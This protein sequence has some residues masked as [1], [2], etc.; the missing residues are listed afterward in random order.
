MLH[1]S[2]SN[3]KLGPIPSV[4]LPPIETCNHLAPC[5]KGDCYACKGRFRFKSVQQS[6]WENLEFYN[7]NSPG[8]YFAEIEK[9]CTTSKYFRYH[10]AGDIPGPTY[11]FFMA[12]LAKKIPDTKFLC[13]TKHYNTVN[14]YIR[15]IGELPKNLIVVFSAWG[16][17]L[18]D[19]PYNLPVS[20]VRLKS[21]E[22]VEHIPNDAR[23]CS[24]Y[25]ADCIV[26][27][28]HCWNLEHGQSVVFNQH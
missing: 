6:M 3:S 20:Y 28:Q 10:S 12:K 2:W 23:K 9:A 27:G 25:C 4:N 22:G 8:A 26:S 16:N 7:S 21:G 5:T 17:F 14:A 24:G 11:F 18:P 1:I 15:T 19:N 13:F